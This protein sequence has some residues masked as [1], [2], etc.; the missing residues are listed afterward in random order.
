MLA[1]SQ[2][3]RIS[4]QNMTRF[5]DQSPVSA[6]LLMSASCLECTRQLSQPKLMTLC[7]A[8]HNNAELFLNLTNNGP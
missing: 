6:G 3:Y 8:F 2:F 5:R 7:K 4:S 1:G